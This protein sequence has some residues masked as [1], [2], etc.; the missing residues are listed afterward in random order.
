MLNAIWIVMM[1]GAIICGALTG[2]LDAVAKA[3]TDSANS[4]V[5]LA[6]GLVGVMTFWLGLMK[7]LHTGGLLAGIA[8]LL[9]PVMV[10]L[11]PDV[12]AD[13][14][15]MSM[16]ILNMTSNVLGL[17]NA[18][19]PFG[20]K[21]MIELER[22]NPYKG[23]ASNAMALFLAIN[24][25]GLAVLPTGMIALRASMGSTAPG[26]IFLTT[27]IST[28]SAAVAGIVT[29]KLL[30]PLPYF[31]VTSAVEGMGV[32][33]ERDVDIA[34]A[35]AQMDQALPPARPSQR[36]FGWGLA[37]AT[38]GAFAYALVMQA[39]KAPE[40]A[41]L[42]GYLDALKMAFNVWPL[43]LLIAGFVLFGVIRG[44]NVYDAL[45]E[46]GKEGFSVALRIIPYLVAI[47]VAVGMLRA[48]GAI[49]MLVAI[50]DPITSLVGMPGQALP[51]ALLRP[52]TG[53]GAYAVAADIMKS[54]GP[55]S[56]TGQIVST[57]MGSTETT[58]YVLALYLGVV[59]IRNVRH[60][61]LPCLVADVTGIMMSVWTCRLLLH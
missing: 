24:T 13:H 19:T 15:A 48:S 40:G 4:A 8:R 34:G 3:S 17:G 35:Q 59:G 33:K 1:I 30:G 47:L 16:M 2:K 23:N 20:L 11:F 10:R 43:V 7:V 39:Q 14:P 45:V 9:R 25:S 53:Q 38:L 22:L 51:M 31:K 27:V 5:S 57:I 42:G 49:D 26:S 12:P 21:A 52:L 61:L 55:D 60:A 6:I 32:P 18:A 29:A 28:L 36:L 41:A 58:F 56:L 54:Q 44:V 46:G 37:L 50:L